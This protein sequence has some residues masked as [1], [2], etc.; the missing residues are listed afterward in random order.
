MSLNDTTTIT[1]TTSMTETIITSETTTQDIITSV[2]HL[3][4]NEATESFRKK[5]N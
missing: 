4:V 3:T 5:L 2:K 1:T